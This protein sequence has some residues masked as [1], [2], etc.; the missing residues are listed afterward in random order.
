MAYRSDD[1]L[2]RDRTF[3]TVTCTATDPPII[4]PVYRRR[5]HNPSIVVRCIIDARIAVAA[6]VVCGAD[7]AF[8]AEHKGRDITSGLDGALRLLDQLAGR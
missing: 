5:R 2:L 3:A 6:S 7:H 8:A 1:T 4:A